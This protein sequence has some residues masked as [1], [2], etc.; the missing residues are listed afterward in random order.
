M[1]VSHQIG[2]P[3]CKNEEQQQNFKVNGFKTFESF[4]F[5]KVIRHPCSLDMKDFEM[6]TIELA[7]CL[8]MRD[9]RTNVFRA[10]RENEDSIYI[11]KLSE[12]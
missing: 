12:W 2:P 11:I 9:I 10:A 7:G 5:T 6:C 4:C 8:N 1:P 3:V